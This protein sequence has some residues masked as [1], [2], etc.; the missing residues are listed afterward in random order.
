M[1]KILTEVKV[2][3]RVGLKTGSWWGHGKI[4]AGAGISHGWEAILSVII[5]IL[6]GTKVRAG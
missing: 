3:V 6:I 1:V 2:M 4:M 5:R